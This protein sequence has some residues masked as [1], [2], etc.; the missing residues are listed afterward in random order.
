MAGHRKWAELRQAIDA[1]LE[2]RA[3][4]DAIKQAYDT[5]VDLSDLRR[6]IGLTQRELASKLDVSQANISRLEHEQDLYI[7]TLRQYIEA[8][9]GRLTLNAVF[10]FG[11]IALELP[12]SK[13]AD[14]VEHPHEPH[15]SS[16]LPW[17][18]SAPVD[19]AER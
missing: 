10:D 12:G 19:Y 16:V 14:G 18:E 2:R 15:H 7:S 5:I 13:I 6:A 1:D 17:A 9:G 11:T 4:R 8:L 3:R